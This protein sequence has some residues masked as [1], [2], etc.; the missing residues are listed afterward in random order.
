MPRPEIRKVHICEYCGKE[1]ETSQAAERCERDHDIVLV[2]IPRIA[3]R[4]LISY[5]VSGD[6][7]YLTRDV[8]E[9]LQKYNK[10]KGTYD[11]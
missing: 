5:T 6:P 11:G 2:K 3:L 7:R 9:I 1:Y 10:L 8:V 4:K